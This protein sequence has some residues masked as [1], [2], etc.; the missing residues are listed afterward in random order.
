MSEQAHRTGK[1]TDS[2]EE[3]LRRKREQANESPTDKI[4]REMKEHDSR[5][6]KTIMDSSTEDAKSLGLKGLWALVGNSSA[7]VIQAIVL[8]ILLF[9]VR[10]MHTEGMS[11]MQRINDAT[12]NVVEKNTKALDSLSDEIRWMRMNKNGKTP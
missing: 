5:L 2:E 4:L 7:L 8:L 6:A 10:G 1:L 3:L 9:Q 12:L 11:Q